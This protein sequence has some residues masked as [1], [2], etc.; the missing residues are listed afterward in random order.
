MKLRVI[1]T[2]ESEFVA[3]LDDCQPSGNDLNPGMDDSGIMYF[4]KQEQG[5]YGKRLK[6]RDRTTNACEILLSQ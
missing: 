2:G 3:I 4:D 5:D 1:K 6:I